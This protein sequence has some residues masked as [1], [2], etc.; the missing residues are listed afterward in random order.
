MN[1]QEQ[2]A[3][4]R[5]IAYDNANDTY[6][7]TLAALVYR[8]MPENVKSKLFTEILEEGD[9]RI[10][11]DM[12]I[13]Y[14]S[15]LI[16][17]IIP[18]DEFIK[19]VTS[20]VEDGMIELEDAFRLLTMESIVETAEEKR[21]TLIAEAE[22]KEEVENNIKDLTDLL[23]KENIP[24]II[25]SIAD[26]VSKE[27]QQSNKELKDIEEDEVKLVLTTSDNPTINGEPSVSDDP[28]NIAGG[29]DLTDDSDNPEND[30]QTTDND[31]NEGNTEDDDNESQKNSEEESGEEEDDD[32][33]ESIAGE[34]GE[35]YSE[36]F[37]RK[38]QEVL[39][40]N[41]VYKIKNSVSKMFFRM[42]S[43]GEAKDNPIFQ[44]QVIALAYGIIVL[45][46]MFK[47]LDIMDTGELVSK[48]DEILEEEVDES[49][50]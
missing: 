5:E 10:T 49:Q 25:K 18:K 14:L 20:K 7:I 43:D 6:G 30:N 16:E 42:N 1:E 48:F 12:Y 3:N 36:A 47:M 21:V 9:T 44:T 11:P 19:R 34:D 8:F 27:I 28:Y 13:P 40:N 15:H 46:F 45:G 35:I 38:Y 39:D 23:D 32:V 50:D 33:P 17:T 26:T 41:L 29:V 37:Q 31:G 4:A 2:L 22:S 24:N